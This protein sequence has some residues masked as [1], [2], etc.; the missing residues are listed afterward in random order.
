MKVLWICG[1]PSEVQREVLRGVDYGANAAWS[2]IMG[3][4]P[5]PPGIELHIACRTARHTAPQEFDYRGAR[6]H[7]VPVKARARLFCLFQF[8]WQYFEPVAERLRPDLIHGWGTEDAYSNIA[9]KLAPRRH[10][11][12]IQGSINACRAYAPMHWITVLSALNERRVLARAGRV[13]AENEASLNLVRTHIRRAKTYVVEHPVREGFLRSELAP[14]RDNQIIFV[15]ALEDRKGLW[16]AME[17]FRV[18]APDDW[19]LAVVGEGTPKAVAD[20]HR[21][22]AVP[23]LKGRA[24]H[25]SGLRGDELVALMCSSSILLL[26]TWIDTGPTVLKEALS[27]GLW[28]VCYDNSG[29]GYYLRRFNCGRLVPD[30]DVSQL[31]VAVRE[32]CEGRPWLEMTFRERVRLEIR[33]FFSKDRIWKDLQ[34]VYAE[35]IGGTD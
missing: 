25:H 29:P 2:W 28:P 3:H 32:V 1:L 7:L 18:A 23:E 17:A 15:G 27:L 22:L 8:D 16:E 20:L 9:L 19:R 5:P 10:L 34:R 35:I 33:P 6:F 11:V 30:R 31:A 13:V 21:Q 24:A 26:P 4:L 14:G 12:Q